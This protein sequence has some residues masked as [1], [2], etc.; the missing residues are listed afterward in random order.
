MDSCHSGDHIAEYMDI[1]TCSI[2][3][4]QQKYCLGMVSNRLHVLPG[5]NP[6]PQFLLWFKAFGLHEGF[7]TYQ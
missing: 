4:P 7:L 6:R 5:P 1:T 2:Q 3:E